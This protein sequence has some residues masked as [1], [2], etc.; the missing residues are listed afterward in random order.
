M[1]SVDYLLM[2]LCAAFLVADLIDWG[3]KRWQRWKSR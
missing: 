2:Y 3:V 1:N